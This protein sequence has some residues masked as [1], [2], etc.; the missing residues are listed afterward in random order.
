MVTL[1]DVAKMA[2][3]SPSTVSNILNGRTNVGEDTKK[4]VLN[5]IEES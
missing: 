1:T 5:I 4:R 3:V 2:G